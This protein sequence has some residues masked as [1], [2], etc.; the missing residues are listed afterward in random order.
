[1]T[2]DKNTK[3]K[4]THG[5]SQARTCQNGLMALESRV[6][7]SAAALVGE[8]PGSQSANSNA[9]IEAALLPGESHSI[10]NPD[11]MRPA[12]AQR[13]TGS[14][15]DPGAD[16]V[17]GSNWNVPE[18]DSDLVINPD[19]MRPAD[20]QRFTGSATDPGADTVRGSNWNVPDLDSVQVINPDSMLPA[21]PDGGDEPEGSNPT[22]HPMPVPEL[23]DLP[24]AGDYLF[25]NRLEHGPG[26]HDSILD[27]VEVVNPDSMRP[28]AN[29]WT[30]GTMLNLQSQIGSEHFPPLGLRHHDSVFDSVMV[31]NPDSMRPAADAMDSSTEVVE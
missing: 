5:S 27:S 12:D 9:A 29:I 24:D 28:I 26:L 13:S 14:A 19:S 31:I 1:M 8:L 30:D 4:A 20:A 11:S 7:F 17:R 23:F 6:L 15:T 25:K 10:I 21:E 18:L 22:P 16:M 2:T 3:G